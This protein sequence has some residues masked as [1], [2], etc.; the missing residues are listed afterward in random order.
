MLG[1]GTVFITVTLFFSQY[2]FIAG[3][4]GYIFV[5]GFLA[6]FMM[7]IVSQTADGE[8]DFPDWPDLSDW[9]DDIAGPMF[10]LVA[11]TLVSF[12]PAVVYIVLSIRSGVSFPVAGAL[13]LMGALYQPMA[14]IAIS[15]LRTARALSPL[16]I[17]PAIAKAPL[18]YSVACGGLL[19]ILAVK[20]VSSW[21]NFIPVVGTLLGNFV[22]LYLLV[23]EMRLLGLLYYSNRD[24]FD[25]I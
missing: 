19:L 13:V 3:M 6:S 1:I 24:K 2:A 23:V 17:I 20:A 16:H 8:V 11:V 14:L 15:I 5:G 21:I 7:K 10:R 18:D 9:W 25:W 22:M 12:G 4:V